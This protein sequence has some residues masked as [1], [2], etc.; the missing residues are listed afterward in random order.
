M[1]AS[2]AGHGHRVFTDRLIGSLP[3][4]PVPFFGPAPSAPILRPRSSRLSPSPSR[5]A[6]LPNRSG[7]QLAGQGIGAIDRPQRLR[8]G[9]DVDRDASTLLFIV[10]VVP[11]QGL[12]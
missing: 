8:N 6:P 3:H 2:S 10:G 12:Q 4:V 5:A 1:S 11:D 7:R 9:A